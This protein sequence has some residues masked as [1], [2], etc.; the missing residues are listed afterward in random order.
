MSL[1]LMVVFCMVLWAARSGAVERVVPAELPA[2]L[3]PW[4]SWALDGVP[5]NDCPYFFNSD[6]RRC[7]WSGP[8]NVSVVATGGE[9]DMTLAIY[10]RAWVALP[11]GDGQWPQ[12]VNVDGSPAPVTAHG[13]RPAVLLPPGRHQVTGRF[14]WMQLPEVLQV[15]PDVALVQ[16]RVEG[17]PAQRIVA[18]SGGQLWLKLKAGPAAAGDRVDSKVYRQLI[19][20]LPMTVVTVLELD[21]AGSQREW[22]TMGML[23]EGA[24]PMQ[25]NSPLP[26]RL[27]ADGLLRVQLRPGHWRIELNSRQAM[28]VTRLAPPAATAPWPEDEVWAFAARTALRLVEVRGGRETDPRQTSVPAEWQGLPTWRMTRADALEFV[29]QRRG[30]PQPQPDQIN[31]ER[32]LWLDF[33]GGGLTVQDHLTGQITRQWRL[34]AGPDLVLGRVSLNGEPQFITQSGTVTRGVEVRR[35]ALDLQ[36]DSRLTRGTLPAIG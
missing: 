21:V 36:A 35:G 7:N 19:D 33:D 12:N 4:V 34:D 27:E 16:L 3:A 23:L 10:A 24:V 22:S 18:A 25:L 30:D 8:L 1:R 14:E 17:V 11:G 20:N 13:G 26:A 32:D 31:L 2:Q 9:F 5:D 6:Q 15:P 29:E 28:P